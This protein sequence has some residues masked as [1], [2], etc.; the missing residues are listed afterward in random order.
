M[1]VLT[2]PIPADINPLQS[3]G[4]RFSVTKL[5][6]LS[7]FC[8]EANIP[9]LI[10][11]EASFT[12]PLSNVPVPGEK[13]QFGPLTIV[14]LLDAQMKNY[15]AI[16]T[17]MLELG[18]PK[19]HEQY[20]KFV[21]DNTNLLSTTELAAGYSDAVLTIL[22]NTNNPIKTIRF[23]DAFPTSLQSV[24]LMT[25]TSQVAYLAGVATF[26]YNYYEFDD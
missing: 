2:C 3:N 8:Q 5:P 24:Q 10:L 15:Q 7:F 20:R 12:N 23:V 22:S 11:P 6:E 17:W 25:D 4:F 13:L 19:S 18:F 14:F 9:Q 21:R 16:H 26:V 1:T